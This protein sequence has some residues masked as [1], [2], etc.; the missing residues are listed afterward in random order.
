MYCR[1]YIGERS[2][3][4]FICIRG[5]NESGNFRRY[6]KIYEGDNLLFKCGV[7]FKG[8]NDILRLNVYMKVYIG[9]IVCDVCGKKFGKILDLY[10][11]IKIYS[12]DRLYK[13]DLCGK[14]F[15]QKV[16]LITYQ[17]IYIGQKVFRC[18][19]CGLGF[20]RKI[21]FQQYM[22]IYLEDE[23]DFFVERI[24][25]RFGKGQVEINMEVDVI[26]YMEVLFNE[27][28]EDG[29][30]QIT[31]IQDVVLEDGEEIIVEVIS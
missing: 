29:E 18:D 20:S 24:A 3:K 27:F 26:E 4:C 15:C 21:I 23:E 7:C 10:R 16:N 2:Y 13:C 11:Y 1:I 8:F 25:V 31:D 30:I 22:K 14:I 12:G 5:F 19:Y 28:V 9:E 17:R 6:M